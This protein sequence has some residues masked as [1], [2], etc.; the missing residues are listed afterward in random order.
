MKPGKRAGV[1]PYAR[2]YY[3]VP[4][5]GTMQH[6]LNCQ[7]RLEREVLHFGYSRKDIFVQIKLQVED[8]NSKGLENNKKIW[9]NPGMC[10]WGKVGSSQLLFWQSHKPVMY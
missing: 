1:R 9:K 10:Q 4:I 2:E 5:V 7:T 3:I 8:F 6:S